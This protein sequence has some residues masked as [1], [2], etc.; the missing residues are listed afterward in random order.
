[1]VKK[2][3]TNLNL[4]T[5]Q[6]ANNAYTIITCIIT[7]IESSMM[8]NYILCV[9]DIE[10]NSLHVLLNGLLV[11]VMI[12]YDVFFWLISFSRMTWLVEFSI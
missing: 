5:T 11:V 3:L 7:W 2:V 4:A 6:R 8:R 1:M 10:V 12:I 9:N